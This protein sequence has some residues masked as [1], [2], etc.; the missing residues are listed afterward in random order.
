MGHVPPEECQLLPINTTA[1]G[2]FIELTAAHF[3]HIVL[4]ADT[5]CC[6]HQLAKLALCLVSKGHH[7]VLGELQ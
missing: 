2:Q 3:A 6:K 4:A 1:S 5:V 7:V